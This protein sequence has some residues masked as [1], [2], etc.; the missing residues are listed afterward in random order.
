MRRVPLHHWLA[1][2]PGV[3]MLAGVPFANRVHRLVL[4]LPCLLVWIL[5]CV[6]L[7]SIVLAWIGAIDARVRRGDDGNERP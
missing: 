5:G 6:V 7:T 3:L 4:G 2:L 1:A